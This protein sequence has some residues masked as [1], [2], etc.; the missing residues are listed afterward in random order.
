MVGFIEKHKGFLLSWEGRSLI[1]V[2]VGLILGILY[3][4]TYGIINGITYDFSYAYSTLYLDTPNILLLVA[5]SLA[6]LAMYPHKVSI[7]LLTIGFFVGG[8][9][10]SSYLFNFIATGGILGLPAGAVLSRILYWLKVIK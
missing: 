9:T 8:L 4:I 2:M 1:G 6:G 5:C 3:G 7:I 10:Q